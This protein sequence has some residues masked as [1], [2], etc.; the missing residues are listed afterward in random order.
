MEIFIVKTHGSNKPTIHFVKT[1]F[2]E[3]LLPI[4]KLVFPFS[5]TKEIS[6]KISTPE[7]DLDIF[8]T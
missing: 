1:D 2:P 6:F 3:P 7:K 5:K 4:I 8:L